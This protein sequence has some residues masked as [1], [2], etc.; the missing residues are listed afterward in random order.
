MTI[1]FN[2]LMQN[3]EA[4]QY[5][6]AVKMHSMNCRRNK[7]ANSLHQLLTSRPTEVWLRQQYKS[8]CDFA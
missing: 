1:H 6:E 3:S 7:Y 4:K 5:M 2:P 8:Q